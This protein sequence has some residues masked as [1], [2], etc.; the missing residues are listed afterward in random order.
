MRMVA[1]FL[2]FI[3][4]VSGC[5]FRVQVSEIKRRPQKYENKQVSVKGKVVET[6]GIP[7]VQ[8]GVYQIDDGSGRIWVV[9]QKHRPS[10]SDKVSVKGVVKTGFSISGHSF[11]IA[12]VE[13]DEE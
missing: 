1:W 13:G 6:V 10:R 11:G 8:K 3:I 2:I 4:F 7:F 12:I 5:A 9:S